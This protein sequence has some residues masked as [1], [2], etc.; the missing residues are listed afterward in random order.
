[1][2][3]I[4]LLE[5]VS[6]L[7][8]QCLLEYF[9]K[10]LQTSHKSNLDLLTEAD[11]AAEKLIIQK[12]RERFPHDDVMAEESGSSIGS[13]GFRW[14]IDP[15][16]GTTNF[17]HSL[18]HFA[19]S[20]GLELNQTLEAGAIF[21]PVRN[22]MFRAVL[23]AGAFL[24][25]KK[26]R[27]SACQIPDKALSVSGF[28]YDR[29]NR[30]PELLSRV[31]KALRNF[32]GFRR[33]GAASLDLAYIASGRLDVFWETGLKPWDLAAGVLIVNESG[34]LI[35][36]LHGQSFDLFA[37]EVLAANPVLHPQVLKVF[38]GE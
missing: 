6:R 15:L 37:G 35:S 5:H 14:I 17:F 10:P 2:N 24:N 4:E 12:I 21:D 19:V 30:L 25:D 29:R 38:Q 31:E 34:G 27:V 32:Q 13:S 3:R 22:E 9:N 16:D 36:G 28:P 1:M 20:I 18:P 11:L 26:I 23:G 7:A 8:G 33:L